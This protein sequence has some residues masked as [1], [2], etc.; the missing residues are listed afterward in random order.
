MENEAT[1]KT[2]HEATIKG[3]KGF[4][5]DLKCSN[6]QYA[7]GEEAVEETAVLCK[8]GLHFCINPHDVFAYYSAGN[9]RFCEVE[10]VD[11]SDEREQDSKRVA[12]HLFVKTE[13]SISHICK[14]A[15]SAFF[16]NFGFK[17]KI[18]SSC[19]NNKQRH[20][21]DLCKSEGLFRT[22]QRF[23]LPLLRLLRIV[24]CG[25]SGLY[26]NPCTL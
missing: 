14:I 11:V 12:K 17:T 19:T 20:R 21:A 23:L 6:K 8:K 4:D 5:K 3:Y 7:I 9:S 25:I 1:I 18:D 15:V 13:I 24:C 22:T 16:E 26:Q 10:A 2:S